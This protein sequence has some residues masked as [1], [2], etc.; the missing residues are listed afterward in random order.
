M[1]EIKIQVKELNDET[2]EVETVG[3]LNGNEVNFLVQFA[4]NYLMA[5]GAEFHLDQPDEEKS[6]ITMPEGTTLQ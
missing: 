3:T 6:R 1:N 5:A 4:I 2:N